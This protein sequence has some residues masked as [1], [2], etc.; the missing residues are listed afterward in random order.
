M[1][2]AQDQQQ[3]S[4]EQHQ[5]LPHGEAIDPAGQSRQLKAAFAFEPSK[6]PVEAVLGR[7]LPIVW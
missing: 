5:Q 3:G 1:G 4:S 6:P 7:L 2:R